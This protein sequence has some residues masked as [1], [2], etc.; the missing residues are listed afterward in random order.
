MPQDFTAD[1]PPRDSLRDEVASAILDAAS[2]LV[3]VLDRDARI[4]SF[5]PACE[6]ATGF[7]ADELLGQEVWRLLPD[8]QRADVEA[9]FQE[10]WDTGRSNFHENDWLTKTGARRRITWSHTLVRGPGGAAVRVVKT[11]I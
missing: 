4:L 10:L 5:N 9:I 1:G 6:Q 3:V 2:L 11:G 7:S 8:D